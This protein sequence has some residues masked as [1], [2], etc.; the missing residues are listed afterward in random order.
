MLD[1][2]RNEL[3]RDLQSM[4]DY[5]FLT[6]NDAECRAGFMIDNGGKEFNEVSMRCA[7]SFN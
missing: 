2:L 4:D 6:S 7:D 5:N 1:A 3:A